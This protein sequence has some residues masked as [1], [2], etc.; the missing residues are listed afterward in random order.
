MW[1]LCL[2]LAIFGGIIVYWGVQEF[3]VSSGTS[4]TAVAAELADLEQGGKLPNKHIKLGEHIA[5]YGE[6][7]YEYSQSKYSSA[8]PTNTTKVNTSYY[9]VISTSND[10]VVKIDELFEKHEGNIPAETPIPTV[11]NFAVLVKTNRFKKVGDIPPHY[12]QSESDL[13]GLVINDIKSLSKEEAKYI[14]QGFPRLDV[15]KVFILEDGRQPASYFKSFGMMGGGVLMCLV[16]LGF[17]VY[18]VS[19]DSEDNVGS[20]SEDNIGSESEKE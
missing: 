12:M 5:L 16:G 1:R 3:R 14:K 9:P 4:A 15:N 2:G 6:I 10:F 11:N 18:S 17:L 7:V 13:K 8:A 19:S 20:E